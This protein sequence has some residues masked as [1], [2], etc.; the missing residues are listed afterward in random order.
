MIEA[1]GVLE[2]YRSAVEAYFGADVAAQFEAAALADRT[3]SSDPDESAARILL[4]AMMEPGSA[5]AADILV[6]TGVELQLDQAVAALK[7]HEAHA[8]PLL[9]AWSKDT[10]AQ[11]LADAIRAGRLLTALAPGAPVF[12]QF[13]V[14][15]APGG[16]VFALSQLS[17]E[18]GQGWA[19]ARFRFGAD[20]APFFARVSMAA[21]TAVFRV[22]A[23]VREAGGIAQAA[24]DAAEDADPIRSADASALFGRS[25]VH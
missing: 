7:P 17:F 3:T 23:M 6:L 4:A 19:T 14:F 15:H 1:N 18:T 25:T 20:V 10:F 13:Q 8:H 21:G 12:D 9:A 5:E 22:G 16:Q 11:A 24:S 2:S